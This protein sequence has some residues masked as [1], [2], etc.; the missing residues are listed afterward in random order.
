MTKET[1]SNDTRL[2]ADGEGVLACVGADESAPFV[3]QEAARLAGTLRLSW[4]ALYVETPALAR[5]PPQDRERVLASLKIAESLGATTVTLGS[6]DVARSILEFARLRGISRVVAGKP[7]RRPWLG[8]LAGSLVGTL[9]SEAEGIHVQLV[10]KE[11]ARD[12][13]ADRKMDASVAGLGRSARAVRWERYIWAAALIGTAA[14]IGWV[15]YPGV[16][17]AGIVMPFLLAVV[18]S[19]IHLGRG[20]AILSA[21]I[22][23]FTFN[24]LFTEPRFTLY[25]H[26]VGDVLTFL[27]LLVVGLA[28]AQ[29]SAQARHQARV[30]IQREE[31]A[32]SLG[33]FT[34]S[35]LGAQT[36][37]GIATIGCRKIAEDFSAEVGLLIHGRDGRLQSALDIPYGLQAIDASIA[38]WI[39]DHGQPAG[40]GTGNHSS[41]PLHYRPLTSGS[42]VIAVLILRPLSP[43]RLFLPEP[44]RALEAYAHQLALA[45]ERIRLLRQTREA[46]LAVQAEDLRNALLSGLSHDLRAP[47]ASILGSASAL[48]ESGNSLSTAAARELLSTVHDETLRMTRLTSN[49]LEMAR[50][51]R[52]LGKLRREWFP[53]EELIGSVRNRLSKLL[54]DRKVRVSLPPD[55]PLVHV[56]GL[57]FEQVLQNLLENAARYSPAGTAIEISVELNACERAPEVCIAVKDEGPG[58]ADSDKPSVFEKFTRLDREAAQSGTG[59][60]LALCKAVVT[61]HGGRIGIGDRPRG[62]AI[63]W[64]TVPFC[65]EIPRPELERVAT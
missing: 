49:L 35:L 11:P 52:G 36:E 27:V 25:I 39:F 18:M 57:L 50:L 34:E 3:I 8:R 51:T 12:T 48:L 9:V 62:G 15:L 23:A 17:S 16:A 64:F 45:L 26:G 38:S 33:A 21:L 14:G 10:S 55:F 44:R 29:L 28:V 6:I 63:F 20:P 31:R 46:E 13:L 40:A 54:R 60:G 2:D 24:F 1:L 59:L 61:L 43:R 19:G 65:A 47:L 5:R 58:I 22:G 53:I 4:I 42:R 32:V 56:D 37:T 41:A 30:A 7:G